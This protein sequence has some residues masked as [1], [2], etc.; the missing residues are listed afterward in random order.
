MV[1]ILRDIQDTAQQ[2]GRNARVVWRENY[3]E[4]LGSS[5]YCASLANI[6]WEAI[7]SPLMSNH[8]QVRENTVK[9]REKERER[10]SKA[11]STKRQNKIWCRNER[12]GNSASRE[13]WRIK[14]QGE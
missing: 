9:K 12:E 5:Y 2:G 13:Y 10:V 1:R 7:I 11:T 4:N 8:H 3:I 14:N 6:V